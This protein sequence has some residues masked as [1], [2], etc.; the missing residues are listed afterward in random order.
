LLSQDILDDIRLED[1]RSAAQCWGGTLAR[2]YPVGNTENLVYACHPGFALRLVSADH[3]PVE[4]VQAELAWLH[5]L[6][7]KRLPVVEILPSPH[8]QL[9]E[10]FTLGKTHLFYGSAFRWIEGERFD[11]L[12][13]PDFWRPARLQSLGSLLAR[14]HDNALKLPLTLKKLTSH[15]P[16]PFASYLS[17][18]GGS[19]PDE[20]SDLELPFLT[21]YNQLQA[22]WQVQ[23]DQSVY[24]GLIHGDLHAGNLIVQ[25]DQL[26]AFDFDD[27]HHGWWTQDIAVVIYYLQRN[28]EALGRDFGSVQQQLLLESYQQHQPLPPHFEVELPVFLQ[29]RDWQLLCFLFARFKTVDAFPPDAQK[30]YAK[31]LQRLRQAASAS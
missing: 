27:A 1:I 5:Y 9:W 26:I 18:F 15:R 13:T 4:A 12:N 7:Q 2:P 10:F 14:L 17:V 31:I 6:Y 19:W 24:T 16:G 22:R 3:R 20:L 28:F 21:L 29:W 30:S 11:S 25:G 8:H 23:K